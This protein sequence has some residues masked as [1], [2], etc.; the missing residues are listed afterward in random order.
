MCSSLGTETTAGNHTEFGSH[1]ERARKSISK[2]GTQSGLGTH[3][4]EEN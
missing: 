1:P 4:S 2:V 3:D